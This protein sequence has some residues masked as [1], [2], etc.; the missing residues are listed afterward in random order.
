MET[1]PIQSIPMYVQCDDLLD[2]IFN[3][4]PLE[5]V[6]YKI[7]TKNGPLNTNEI[8][9]KIQR[10]RSTAYRCL[11]H[12]ISCGICYKKKV[13][14]ADGGYIHI[15]N[16]LSPDE[17]REKLRSC[18]VNWSKRMEE[19]VDRFPQEDWLKDLTM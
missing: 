12:L 10:D 19:A 9:E 11:R 5:I 18:V 13:N 3:L 15:Y 7:L 14:L 17:V 2:C 4:N 16:V 1:P 8:T 6:V